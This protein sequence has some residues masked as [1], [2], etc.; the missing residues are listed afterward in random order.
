MQLFKNKRT[1]LTSLLVLLCILVTPAAALAATVTGTLYDGDTP[2]DDTW[3]SIA[4]EDTGE[5]YYAWVNEGTFTVELPD[6]GNYVAGK[7]WD[8]A[9][10][11]YVQLRQAFTVTDDVYLTKPEST[12]GGTVTDAAGNTVNGWL[13]IHEPSASNYY[14]ARITNGSFGLYLPDGNYTAYGFWNE[15]LAKYVPLDVPIAVASGVS[16]PVDIVE[17]Q[18]NLSGTVESAE[19]AAVNGWVNFYNTTDQGWYGASIRTGSF[20]LSAPEGVYEID[21]YWDEDL[22]TYVRLY[23]SFT[24]AGDDPVTLELVEPAKNVSGGLTR[25]GAAIAGVWVNFRTEDS[26][27][28]YSA[29][30]DDEGDY[31]IALPDGS[32]VMEGYWSE[33][34]EEYVGLQVSFSIENS[35]VVGSPQLTIDLPGKNV[36]G[37]LT[38][39]EENPIGRAWI[40]FYDVDTYEWYGA[41]TAGNGAFSLFLPDG[42]YAVD[43]FWNETTNEY[44][45]L[46]VEFSVLNGSLDGLDA[47]ELAPAVKNVFGT[48]KSEVGEPFAKTWINFRNKATD[49]W[50]NAVTNGDGAFGLHLDDG[51]YEIQGF[52]NEATQR[53][54]E[55]RYAFEVV[56]G[57]AEKLELVVM[58]DNVIGSLRDASLA[59]IGE[60][61]LNIENLDTQQ[62]YSAYVDA[63]GI[64]RLYLEDGNYR[65][66]GFWDNKTNRYVETFNTFEIKDGEVVAEDADALDVVI[67]DSNVKG[68]ILSSSNAPVA[69]VH[70][71]IRTSDHSKYFHTQTDEEGKFETFLPDGDYVIEG[72]WDQEAQEYVRLAVAFSVA[73]GA[74]TN[75]SVLQIV[76]LDKNVS[77]TLARKDG[78]A[79]AFAFVNI[80][81]ESH[82]NWYG[83][84]TNTSGAFSLYLPDG[85]YVV[86]G[87]SVP[88][89]TSG[90][91]GGDGQ[92]VSEYV[93]LRVAFSV[94][95]GSVTDPS[96]LQLILQ[97]KNVSG[98][99]VDAEGRPLANVQVSFMRKADGTH[100]SARTNANG[101]FSL[102]LP[103]GEY[104][105]KGYWNY[106]NEKYVEALIPFVVEGETTLELREPVKNVVGVVTPELTIAEAFL[107]VVRLDENGA[108]GTRYNTRIIENEFAM[109]LEDGDYIVEGYY[110]PANETY[111]F[112]NYGFTVSNG[113]PTEQPL[114]VE[115]PSAQ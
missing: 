69:G 57:E 3:L 68:S 81:N 59:A 113:V 19:G 86:D 108:Q 41:K 47:L 31:A 56:G 51:E 34:E 55:F 2:V 44:E 100:Y 32:Y 62:W 72:Y 93:Q 89:A 74:P 106:G 28:W 37:T 66:A 70:V 22:N 63:A 7:Y 58:D 88:A 90:Q 40:N 46:Y 114:I 9:N 107:N 24:I 92:T 83:A 49:R 91:N 21:G 26:S 39:V 80:R 101:G 87:V 99:F 75:E 35:V 12:V 94:L 1:Y 82:T 30:T 5:E 105:V 96:A 43:G 67:P 52:W 16:A 15:L 71:T 97:D 48:L 6:D 85:N 109:A 17:P 36:A 14:Y 38:D 98:T 65:I 8:E 54:V 60:V 78:T 103:D 112:L 18:K 61:W 20:E 13:Y 84:S 73:N 115:A 33:A 27:A 42:E 45:K 95:N 79:V 76:L 110:D 104:E 102:F 53:Y 29:F 10:G 11:E 4:N 25:E 111:V 23:G 77:G 64:Y 50:F